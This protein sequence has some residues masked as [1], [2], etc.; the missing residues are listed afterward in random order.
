[1]STSTFR[2]TLDVTVN[3][4]D[5]ADAYGMVDTGEIYEAVA[6]DVIGSATDQFRRAGIRASISQATAGLDE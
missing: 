5:Y 2:L 1:M 3:V 4:D 6:A